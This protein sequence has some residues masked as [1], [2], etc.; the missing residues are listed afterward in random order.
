M[1]SSKGCMQ[2]VLLVCTTLLM[3]ICL[4]LYVDKGNYSLTWNNNNDFNV[5]RTV[6]KNALHVQHDDIRIRLEYYEDTLAEI[7]RQ[8]NN[9][10]R[11]LN[12]QQQKIGQ[13]E[14]EKSTSTSS[15][16][17]WCAQT[18]GEKSGQH[19]T[20]NKLAS[21]LAEFFKGKYVAS[22]G[23]GPGRYKQLL[24]DTGLLKG[25]DAYDGAP[26][27]EKTS[28]G[29][30]QF[31]DLTLPQYGLPM[32]DWI[33][34]LEVAE[35]IPKEHESVFVDNVVRHAKEGI[36]LS[37]AKLGQG[38]YQHVNNQPIEYV[39]S[40][41]DKLGFVHDAENSTKLQNA[42]SLPW[43]QWNTNVYWRKSVSNI[44]KI[45]YLFS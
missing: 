26:F 30:V 9:L 18:S 16:G 17:G 41:F 13:M 29:R 22:F 6:Q 44:D 10:S 19:A 36:V 2:V 4:M 35:H 8:R 43:L 12:L 23:D 27:S 24:L 39:K 11:A 37:W 15:T 20:D 25:Y 3:L 21:V 32:Y 28:E 33:L 38:G 42:A 31:L 5:T 1:V 45:N 34:S 14:C 40:L 7:I